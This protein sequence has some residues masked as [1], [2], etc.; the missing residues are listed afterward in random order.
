MHLLYT[1][2]CALIA[3]MTTVNVEPQQASMHASFYS[4]NLLGKDN[5]FNSLYSIQEF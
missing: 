5:F 3:M 1:D 4:L 2:I